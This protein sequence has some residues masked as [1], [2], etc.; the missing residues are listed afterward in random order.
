MSGSEH[1]IHYNLVQVQFQSEFPF[2]NGSG[3]KCA[4]LTSIRVE[5]TSFL[6]N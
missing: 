6:G 2:K 4:D 5:F 1:K 3:K